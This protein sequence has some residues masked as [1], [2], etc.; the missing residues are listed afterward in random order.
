MVLR[1][2][3]DAVLTIIIPDKHRSWT[4]ALSDIF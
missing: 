4:I 3:T 1:E 2:A